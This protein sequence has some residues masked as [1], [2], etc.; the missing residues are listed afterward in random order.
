MDDLEQVIN[1]CNGLL[2]TSN[3]KPIVDLLR[4]LRERL[5]DS[6]SNLKPIAAKLIGSI[7]SKADKNAQS[8][9]GKVIFPAVVNSALNDIK[10]P[11]RDAALAA[12]RSGTT[13]SDLEGGGPNGAALEFFVAALVSGLSGSEYK[14]KMLCLKLLTSV[15]P[16]HDFSSSLLGK[17]DP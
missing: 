6:Q 7:L 17:W 5:S 10:K 15:P 1:S 8:N 13:M 16:F 2:E 3:L 4:A 11:M 12:I 9:L 14:V